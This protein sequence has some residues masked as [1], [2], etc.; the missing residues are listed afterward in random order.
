[1]AARTGDGE[2]S[3]FTNQRTNFEN[4]FWLEGPS[5]LKD[6]E[7]AWPTTL[8]SKDVQKSDHVKGDQPRRHMQLRS[9]NLLALILHTSQA[10]NVYIV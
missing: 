4:K 5:F 1:M 7:S 2:S 8:P 10:S 6:G 3:G 9:M